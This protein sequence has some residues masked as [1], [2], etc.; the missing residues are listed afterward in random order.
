MEPNHLRHV[1]STLSLVAL[2][3]ACPAPVD[4]GEGEATVTPNPGQ[5]ASPMS[6]DELNDAATELTCVGIDR[7]F[8]YSGKGAVF[9]AMIA[10]FGEP[11]NET[12]CEEL[13]VGNGLRFSESHAAG[14]FDL[15]EAGLAVCQARLAAIDCGEFFMANEL[16]DLCPEL[17]VGQV[18]LGEAC[19]NAFECAQG[20]FCAGGDGRCGAC[21]AR[22][23][24]GMPCQ[25]ENSCAAGLSCQGNTCAAP[26][27]TGEACTGEISSCA[28]GDDV[29]VDGVCLTLTLVGEG[30]P[31]GMD[32][33]AV[34]R[35][36]AVCTAQD[37]GTCASPSTAVAAL[38]ERCA[39]FA[40]DT[41]A[42]IANCEE[43]TTCSFADTYPEGTCVALVAL[44]EACDDSEGCAGAAYC[45]F[46]E[47][48][49][50]AR[51][52]DG[53]ACDDED[54]E[55]LS[56]VCINNLCAPTYPLCE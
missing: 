47:E 53:E 45:D 24:A 10:S 7:C 27:A 41:Y 56:D 26:V 50:L 33:G 14:R 17:A 43:G 19:V 39:S 5:P 37:S 44:G 12:F 46:I 21:E 2:L 34:C 42:H 40:D 1:I 23:A 52:P 49:C 3:S 31:C 51:K 55:C 48:V 18:A 22:V 54:D 6:F 30:E 15:D 13:Q 11:I 35:G 4:S 25:N 9:T 32:H 28:G 8:L 29:C 38:G 20:S 36:Y 16:S